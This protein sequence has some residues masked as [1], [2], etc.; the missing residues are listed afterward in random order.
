[1]QVFFFFGEGLG[2]FGFRHVIVIDGHFFWLYSASN[3][4]KF[5]F[6]LFV[7]R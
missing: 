5:N 3:Y 4:K 1:M 7:G 2:Q 6:G